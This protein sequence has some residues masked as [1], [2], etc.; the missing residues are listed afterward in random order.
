MHTT[1]WNTTLVAYFDKV[2]YICN[3]SMCLMNTISLRFGTAIKQARKD[4][5]LSQDELAAM[6]GLTKCQISRIENGL[7]RS[8][9]TID[10]VLNALSLVPVIELEPVKTALTSLAVI[11]ALKKYKEE[12]ASEYGILKLGLFGSY[13]RD[14]QT[15]DSDVDVCVLLDTPSYMTRAAIKEELE[16]ILD[17][18][19]DVISLSARMADGFKENLE[20]EV[21]Y[22]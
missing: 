3:K 2:A 15:I 22:V 12:N 13:A 6:V 21:I 5:H 14:E 16:A 9:S 11:K 4:K 1:D 7:A 17:R 10:S 20:N 19:V 8:M 18:E